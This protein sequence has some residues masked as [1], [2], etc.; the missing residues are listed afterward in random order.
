M[1]HALE[2]NH[3]LG[4]APIVQQVTGSL[5]ITGLGLI[6]FAYSIVLRE[7]EGGSFHI[8]VSDREFP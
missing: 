3:K 4:F 8:F 2:Q 7:M 1:I 6:S 5:D